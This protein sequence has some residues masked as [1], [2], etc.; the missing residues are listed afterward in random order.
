[1]KDVFR[2]IVGY[3]CFMLSALFYGFLIVNCMALAH[4]LTTK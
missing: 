2:F 3:I 1:M 4:Y